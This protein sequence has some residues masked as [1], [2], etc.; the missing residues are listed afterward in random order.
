MGIELEDDVPEPRVPDGLALGAFRP[1]DERA[2]H[3]A[4]QEAFAEHWGNVTE[5]FEHW[6]AR[7]VEGRDTSLWL[8][9][10][11][12]DEIAA[13]SVNQ[14]KRFGGGWIAALGVRKAWRRRG[15]AQALL[16]ASFQAFRGR[17]E[18]LVRLGVD[19]ENPTGAVQLY[20]RAGMRQVWRADVYRK[21]L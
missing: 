9:V 20:E 10:R 2:V 13:A 17:G 16:L 4:L 7:R 18:T 11:A 5:T 6:R 14:W 21:K 12:G 15:L 3:A 1:E 8:V 19:S